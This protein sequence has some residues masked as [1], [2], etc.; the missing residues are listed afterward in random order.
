METISKIALVIM[1][2]VVV[3]NLGQALYFMMTDKD[4]D[5]RTVW[6]LTRRIGLSLVLIAMIVIG[7]KLG[8]IHL[9][10]VGQ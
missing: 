9:H 10:G 7:H 3:F 2:L 5:R 4:D 1:F 6:A 8:W